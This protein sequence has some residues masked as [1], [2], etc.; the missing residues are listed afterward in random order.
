MAPNTEEVWCTQ[1]ELGSQIDCGKPIVNLDADG[2]GLC[3][4]GHPGNPVPSGD[5]RPAGMVPVGNGKKSAKGAPILR[6]MGPLDDDVDDAW[7]ADNRL[8]FCRCGHVGL[9]HPRGAVCA[10]RDSN[11]QDCRCEDFNW[12]EVRQQGAAAML[13]DTD[14][15]ELFDG[16]PIVQRNMVF[17]GSYPMDMR[18]PVEKELWLNLKT[19]R[20]GT[21]RVG[22]EVTGDGHDKVIKKDE[23][24]G[25][26]H[27]RK[28]QITGIALPEA[29]GDATAGLP[30]FANAE[31]EE[32][33]ELRRF[34]DA[35]T[36]IFVS[37][38]EENTMTPLGESLAIAAGEDGDE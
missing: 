4:A 9:S 23:Y 17:S 32:L 19:G 36:V 30:L 8:R 15:V 35:H 2:F 24:A 3:E 7:Q 28:I 26:A 21:F 33:L 31:R 5:W 10:F 6:K 11:G 20:K 13:V 29:A 16:K 25:I 1:K 18:R 22:W 38:Q 34:R 27:K 37:W 14:E 12:D